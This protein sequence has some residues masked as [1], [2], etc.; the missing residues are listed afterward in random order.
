MYDVERLRDGRSYA[1]RRV[2]AVQDRRSIFVLD[3]SF[4][5]ADQ[6]GDQ[7]GLPTYAPQMPTY[8]LEPEEG[9][10]R[11]SRTR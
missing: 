11:S 6:E 8:D 9:A 5:A 7:T 4:H 10:P 1:T 2:K 3:C